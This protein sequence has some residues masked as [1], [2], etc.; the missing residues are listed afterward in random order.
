MYNKTELLNIKL[1]E[2]FS[3]YRNYV[4]LE[5][6]V[7][8]ELLSPIEDY[9]EA[10]NLIEQNEDIID[11]LNLYYVAAYLCV[12]WMPDN[13]KF[14]DKLNCI[15]SSVDDTAKAVIYYLNAYSLSYANDSNDLQTYIN[16]LKRSIEFS[17]N[18]RFVN[19]RLDLAQ[20]L[21]GDEDEK[22]K[23]DA[24]ENVESVFTET[25][26]SHINDEE[27]LKI[28]L[29]SQSYIDEFILGTHMTSV[30]YEAKFGKKI[31]SIKYF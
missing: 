3:Q 11:G 31:R 24:L 5:R 8:S 26:L 30:V 27:W 17:K 14:I 19:N 12:E 13:H 18:I 23:Q 20:V 1:H 6:Y 16:H 9:Y 2:E 15:L 10:I 7:M 22:Y 29:N 25:E 4:T 21:S 28:K